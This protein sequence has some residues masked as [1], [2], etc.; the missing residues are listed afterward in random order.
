M[1]VYRKETAR[2]LSS[3]LCDLTNGAFLSF[4]FAYTHCM[5][6]Y[7]K[8][9]YLLSFVALA[10]FTALFVQ[11]KLFPNNNTLFTILSPVR[12]MAATFDS[13]VG[14]FDPAEY[15]TATLRE[16]GLYVSDIKQG[17]GSEVAFGS[18]VS[19]QYSLSTITGVSLKKVGALDDRFS[20]SIGS[21]DVI[22]GLSLGLLGM[23]EGGVRTIVVPPK[24][25]YDDLLIQGV[26]EGESLVFTVELLSV[27]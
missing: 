20:F 17:K 19:I 6:D 16:D 8:K 18:E 2:F 22:K 3:F 26:P 10:S 9:I 27:K 12:M 5:V 23:K 25:G 21:S 13:L 7:K 24:Y 14:E 15:D 11:S 4:H 1:S